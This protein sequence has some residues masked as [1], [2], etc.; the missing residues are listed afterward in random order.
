MAKPRRRQRIA[1]YGVC[2]EDGEILLT[3]AAPRLSIAGQWFLPGGGVDHGEHPL[4]ALRREFLEETGLTVVVGGLREVLSDVVVMRDG[5]EFHHI[6]LVYD[7]ESH[8]GE[9][10][11]ETDGSSDDARWFPVAKALALPLVP[12]ARVVLEELAPAGGER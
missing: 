2:R 5:D 6:R 9:L 12:Y 1:T 3:R 8:S 11:V 7:I 4:E 10:R